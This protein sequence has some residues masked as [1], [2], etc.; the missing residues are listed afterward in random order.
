MTNVIRLHKIF[1]FIF[2]ISWL[3]VSFLSQCH[4]LVGI[5]FTIKYTYIYTVFPRIVSAETILFWKWKM[6]KFSYSFRIMAIFYFIN[7]IGSCRRNYWR[8][9]TIR[10]NTVS[11]YLRSQY[12]GHNSIVCLVLQLAILSLS[13]S[14]FNDLRIV[15]KY[16]V[17]LYLIHST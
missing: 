3:Q 5:Y 12:Q 11:E 17:S 2:R 8:G 6:W 15:N 13:D 16:I 7:W 1:D 10:G 14:G 4:K 9:E